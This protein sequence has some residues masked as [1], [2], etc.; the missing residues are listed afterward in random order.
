MTPHDPVTSPDHYTIYPV[1]PIAITRHLGFC[2]GNAVKYV[3][4]APYK[5]NAHQ[6]LKKA[7]QY[8]TWEK[9]GPAP[10]LSIGAYN[11]VEKV[12]EALITHLLPTSQESGC[13]LTVAQA[14]TQ[15]LQAEFLVAL[16]E[17]LTGK[18]NRLYGM[19]FH[20]CALNV[21]LQRQ[22]Q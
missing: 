12:C 10:S 2:L 20:V 11:Q 1:Q 6:D 19:K 22:P 15:G 14:E 5:G 8:L 4:R 17:Y 7:L 18:S 9:E 3:L 16:C 21:H 13:V